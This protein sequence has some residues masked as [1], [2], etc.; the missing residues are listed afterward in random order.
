MIFNAAAALNMLV[1]LGILPPLMMV[2]VYISV[3]LGIIYSFFMLLYL[4]GWHKQ[5]DFHIPAAYAPT[6]K[7]SVIIPARNEEENIE[8]CIQA[9]LAQEYPKELF[10]LIIVD[11]HSGDNT[12]E[13]IKSYPQVQ[14]LNLE[15]LLQ[16]EEIHTAYKKKAL[17]YGIE[18][19]TGDL[20]VTT[21]ADC[22]MPAGWLKDIAAMYQRDKP[23]MIVAPV[24]FTHSSRLVEVFQALDFMSMQ[25]IT[26]A[27]I[28]LGL[29]NMCNGA[30]LAFTKQAYLHV[31]GYTGIDHIASGDDYLLM[32]KLSK[33]FPGRINYLKSK[34]AIVQTKPQ[35]DW[36]S[37]LQ[38]RIR[39]ASKSGKYEDYKIT[40]VLMMV[41]LFNLSFAGL[42]FL[43]IW[44]AAYWTYMLWILLVKNTFEWVYLYPVARFY[45][46]TRQLLI[47]PLL[48]PIHILYVIS[49]GFMG[50]FG[51]YQ[52]KGRKVK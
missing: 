47:F 45:N 23:V 52:W 11:D 44:D 42:L 10:E 36:N 21:D 46:K 39:W 48:Q 16:D 9:V 30:N 40:A 25:G 33:A 50:F 17:S 22:T 31:G 27:T 1:I 19:C 13:I 2:L 15:E 32:M 49:A 28:N 5:T 18:H 6:T 26:V 43:G 8:R 24:V 51:N 20:I 12:A 35:P 34:S 14:Y 29:G 38:Q 7:I 37:F 3:G 4:Y 41:Y